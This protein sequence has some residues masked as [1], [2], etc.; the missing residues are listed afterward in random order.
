VLPT[1]CNRRPNS[2]AAPRV[3]WFPSDRDLFGCVGLGRTG[4]RCV[5]TLGAGAVAMF[6]LSCTLLG[7]A[8]GGGS[9]ARLRIWATWMKAFVVLDPYVREGTFVLV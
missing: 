4:G 8:G 7:I 5:M 9:V 1:P 3:H 6:R 2:F